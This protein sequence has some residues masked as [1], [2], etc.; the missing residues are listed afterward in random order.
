MTLP[1]EITSAK[2]VGR[3]TSMEKESQNSSSGGKVL[4]LT[5]T[6]LLRSVQR[7]LERTVF[8]P[9]VSNLIFDA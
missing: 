7:G 6:G 1:P 3:D 5:L 9:C 8:E 4:S 2:K